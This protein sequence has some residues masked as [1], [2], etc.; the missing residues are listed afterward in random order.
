MRA[1]TAADRGSRISNAG[2]NLRFPA[3]LGEQG[4]T[5]RVRAPAEPAR[6]TFAL[7]SRPGRLPQK[8][9][10]HEETPGQALAQSQAPT[11]T[12]RDDYMAVLQ[13]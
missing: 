2:D 12:H 1:S 7:V 6:Q 4:G 11:Q 8:Q 5:F 10:S 3:L 13:L 9:H